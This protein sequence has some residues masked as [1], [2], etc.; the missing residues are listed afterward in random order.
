MLGYKLQTTQQRVIKVFHGNKLI[1]HI[2][3]EVLS[4]EGVTPATSSRN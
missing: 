2:C 1:Q 3:L 4:N